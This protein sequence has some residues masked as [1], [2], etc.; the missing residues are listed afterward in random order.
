M[1]RFPNVV[2]GKIL[3][4]EPHPNADRLQLV[5]VDVGQ[6]LK[7]VCGGP[8]IALGQ[9]VPVALVG[10]TLAN[11]MVIEKILIRGVESEGML[12]SER[13]LGLGDDHSGIL[14]LDNGKVG[15]IIDEYVNFK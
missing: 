4:I 7:I 6:E 1:T 3:T 15:D 11:G 13:E 8:N 14:I 9:F 5:T 10:A 12:C 2:V